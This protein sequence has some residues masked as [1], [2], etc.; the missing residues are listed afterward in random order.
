MGTLARASARVTL[1]GA[2]RFFALKVWVKFSSSRAA[3]VVGT[4]IAG[5]IT[6]TLVAGKK[7]VNFMHS[8]VAGTNTVGTSSCNRELG[9]ALVLVLM[10]E[11]WHLH[12]H[13]CSYLIGGGDK[14]LC[15]AGSLYTSPY[16]STSPCTHAWELALMLVLTLTLY[17]WLDKKTLGISPCTQ[18]PA[19]AFTPGN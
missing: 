6:Q 2:F 8:Q 1:V 18:Q 13:S 9:L 10:P 11:S 15:P 16:T 19:L 4:I 3:S 5:G 14:K 17:R 12:Y 7:H